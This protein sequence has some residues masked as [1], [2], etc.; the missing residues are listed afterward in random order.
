M[1]WS[2]QPTGFACGRAVLYVVFLP[3][4]RLRQ[5]RQHG[6]VS[7]CQRQKDEL[8][9][10]PGTYLLLNDEY[11]HMANQLELIVLPEPS[12]VQQAAAERI[13][14]IA[15][16][17]VA[18]KHTFS[19]ALSGGTMV[20]GLY[21][22]LAAEPLRSQMPWQHVY[23][24]WGDERY[25]PLD[26]PDSNYRLAWETLLE[27]VPIPPEQIYPVPT[28][29]ADPYEAAAVYDRQ[30]QQVLASGQGQ[31]DVMVM[32][33]GADGHTAS[34]FPYHPALNLPQDIL[35]TAVEHAPK[36]PR[37]RISL[38]PTALNCAAH[39]LFLVTG[40]EKAEMLREVLRG[41]HD[42]QRLPAQLVRPI[43]GTLTWFV[44]TAAGG[45]I[46]IH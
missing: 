35:V 26:D 7:P 39:A 3:T 16:D 4:S 14:S 44:D 38:T 41:P 12:D 34:L 45:G 24:L 43:H 5:I 11:I 9:I 31:I 20:H 33:M 23:V 17:R 28:F 42:P 8:T 25:V 22:Y 13:V 1:R 32:G 30:V 40:N 19:I 29:Y 46:Q 2:D 15:Q 37:L 27:H 36:P 10:L 18:M 6:N 21:R